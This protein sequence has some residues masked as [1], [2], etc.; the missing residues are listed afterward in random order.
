MNKTNFKTVAVIGRYQ[1]PA[2]GATLLA[3]AAL[4]KSIGLK[5]LIEAE[6]AK[7][8]QLDHDDA[9]QTTAD[10]ARIGREADLAVVVGGDGT[11]LGIARALS[12]YN[13][14]LVGINHGRLGFITDVPLALWQETVTSIVAGQYKSEDRTLLLAR[15]LRGNTEVFAAQALNDVVISRGTTGRMVDVQVDVDGVFM[16]SQRADGL[17][18]STPT[19]S[20]AYALSAN[21]PILH[22]SLAGL[23]LVPVAPQSL[24]NR[25]IVLPEHCA[26]SIRVHDADEARVH[27]DMQEFTQ[28]QEGDVIQV[29]LSPHRI[30][31]LHPNGHSHFA[32]LRQKLNWQTMP[33]MVERN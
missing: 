24:S 15:V 31:F 32:T 29:S 9:W 23:V 6:S 18:I 26:I 1:T 5:V 3:I 11:M 7:A 27:C 33:N 20:T 4:F 22:P 25:P 10:V 19:G 21:G 12:E 13:V 16:Y 14:P 2:I 17:I 8:L 28:L 30:T